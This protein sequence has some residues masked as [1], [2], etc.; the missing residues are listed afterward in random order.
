M[1]SL[2]YLTHLGATLL[3]TGIIWLVQVVQYPLFAAVGKEAFAAYHSGHTR[4]IAFVVL[5][6]MLVELAGALGLV[7]AP[8]PGVPRLGAL[9]G[10]ALLGAIWASTAFVQVPQHGLLAEGFDG[11]AWRQLVAGN[12]LRTAAWTARAVLWLA[13]TA[14]LLAPAFARR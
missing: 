2:L 9:A 10:L 11:E 8:P 1:A 7:I 12:W 6:V 4:Q 13:L 14:P 3:M 5:P